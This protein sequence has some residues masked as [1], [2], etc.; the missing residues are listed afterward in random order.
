VRFILDTDTCIWILRETEPVL[1]RVRAQSPDDLAVTA[2]TEAE[3][4][5]GARNSR[6]PA[7]GLA[8][9]EALLSAPLETL[10]FDREAARWYAEIRYAL[11]AT[12]IGE[13]DLVIASVVVA[14]G[15]TLVTHNSNEFAPVP[16]LVQVDWTAP[17]S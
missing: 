17:A 3:L 1:S 9:V 5:Y 10:A 14:T 6:D 12:P 11:R 15:H 13:R 16:G 4:R 7:A 8:R 2:M